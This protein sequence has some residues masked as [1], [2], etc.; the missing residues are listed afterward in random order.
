MAPSVIRGTIYHTRLSMIH[1]PIANAVTSGKTTS[2]SPV[3]CE[4]AT[5]RKTIPNE[6]KCRIRFLAYIMCIKYREDKE[7]ST[8]LFRFPPRAET[9]FCVFL[10]IFITLVNLFV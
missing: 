7:I 8:P 10:H 1:R 9:L 4:T 3:H 5:M 6:N 2:F